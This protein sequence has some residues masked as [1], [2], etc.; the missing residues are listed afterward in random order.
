MHMERQISKC[1][2][3]INNKYLPFR[4]HTL[5][6]MTDEKIILSSVWCLLYA[7]FVGGNHKLLRIRTD[8]TTILYL[9]SDYLHIS[10]ISQ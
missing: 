3:I 1:L 4:M 2:I 5:Q 8:Y 7:Y 10:F 9:F 6:E